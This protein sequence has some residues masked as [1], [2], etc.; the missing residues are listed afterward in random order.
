[1]RSRGRKVCANDKM[2]K[3]RGTRWI[4][5]AAGG[6]CGLGFLTSATASPPLSPGRSSLSA[7]DSARSISAAGRSLAHQEHAA[8]AQLDL[9]PP[10]DSPSARIRGGGD[11][12]ASPFPSSIHHLDL[13]KI[14]LD[15]DDRIHLPIFATVEAG[16]RVMSPAE[17]YARRL[18]REGLPLARLWQ[19]KSAVLSIGLNNR[20]KPGLWLTQK[21]H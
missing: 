10:R 21:V 15:N 13:G 17:I 12:P 8:P 14:A 9:L 19:S 2:N 4:G 11:A 5:V 18:H 20:G 1:V 16:G 7:I 6:L 3:E